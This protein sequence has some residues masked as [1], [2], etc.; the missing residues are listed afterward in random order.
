MQLEHRAIEQGG[1]R[2]GF[3]VRQ[4][5]RAMEHRH[6]HDTGTLASVVRA[7]GSPS[8]DVDAL[9]QFVKKIIREERIV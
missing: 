2:L 9:R 1:A 6:R 3:L 7:L 4:F 8:G 5:R